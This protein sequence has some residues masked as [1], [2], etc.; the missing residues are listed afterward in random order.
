MNVTMEP[1]LTEKNDIT[2]SQLGKTVL[3]ELPLSTSYE[4]IGQTVWNLLHDEETDSWQ[5]RGIPL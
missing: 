1:V 5:C 4:Q 3:V 2:P